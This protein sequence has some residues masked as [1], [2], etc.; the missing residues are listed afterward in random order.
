M[1]KGAIGKQNVA[2]KMAE[3]FG[4]DWIGEV[5][6]KWY[7]WTTENGERI[8]IAIAM[9][10]PK[11]MVDCGDPGAGDVEVAGGDFDWSEA[12]PVAPAPAPK[13]ISEEE[14]Q[15]V[16]DLMAKLGL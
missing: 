14:K 1:A 6:K 2:K 7:V 15:T 9:T 12:Q 13:E 5:D 11:V 16:A 10:C 8:Q 4:A 3:A